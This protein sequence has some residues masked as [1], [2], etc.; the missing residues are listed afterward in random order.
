MASEDPPDAVGTDDDATPAFL[1]EGRTD[2]PWA[3]TRLAEGKGDDPLLGQLAR[4]VGHP[5]WPSLPRPEHL[6]PTPQD[7]S[8]PAVVGRGVNPEDPARRPDVAEFPCQA[9][10]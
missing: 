4:L 1:A 10:Q 9:E 7:R 2:P 6:E 3:K 8:A 5:R